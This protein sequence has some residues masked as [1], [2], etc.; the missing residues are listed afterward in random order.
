MNA[1]PV[2]DTRDII[3]Y[4]V[5]NLLLVS[6]VLTSPELLLFVFK[7]LRNND[8]Y[9]LRKLELR[10]FNIKIMGKKILIYKVT[11]I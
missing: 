5:N 2:I 10:N 11:D 8:G 4:K 3:I 9:I 6:P 7:F 1:I